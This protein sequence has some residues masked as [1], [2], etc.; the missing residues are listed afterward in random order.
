[1]KKR[2]AELAVELDG[3]APS[4]IRLHPNL[5]ELYR[6]KVGGLET[7]LAEP[8]SQSEALEILRGLV[9]RVDVHKDENGFR[10]DMTGEITH[11]LKLASGSNGVLDEPYSSSVKVVAGTRNHRVFPVRIEV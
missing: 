11:M 4:R 5:A 6:E 3:A 9:E 10:I 7:A 8:E 2:K 1:L